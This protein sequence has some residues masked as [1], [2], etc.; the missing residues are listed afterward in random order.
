M[1]FQE[2]L[3]EEVELIVSTLNDPRLREVLEKAME[4]FKNNMGAISEHRDIFKITQAVSNSL[5]MLC[6]AYQHI[7]IENME[8]QPEDF[9]H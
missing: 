3:K 4:V 6:S 7:E 9:E 1:L 2:G 8:K 5:S